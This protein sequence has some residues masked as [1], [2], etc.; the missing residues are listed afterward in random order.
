MGKGKGEIDTYACFI[1][2]GTVLFEIK[3]VP[4]NLAKE[5]FSLGERKLNVKCKFIHK[6]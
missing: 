4:F 5:A 3:D 1:K 6:T 2:K